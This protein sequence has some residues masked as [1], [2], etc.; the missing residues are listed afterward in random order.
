[1]R[2]RSTIV[3]ARANYFVLCKA[4]AVNKTGPLVY[5]NNVAS[6]LWTT[7]SPSISVE[8]FESCNC[9][10]HWWRAHLLF[11]FAVPCCVLVSALKGGSIPTSFSRLAL[12]WVQEFSC[13]IQVKQLWEPVV[14]RKQPTVTRMCEVHKIFPYEGW[15]SSQ[16]GDLLEPVNFVIL[17]AT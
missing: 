12:F 4:Y 6:C 11:P 16:S 5:R 1:M 10:S 15:P 7:T 3:I 9:L 14:P 8:C 17:F 2:I 13:L